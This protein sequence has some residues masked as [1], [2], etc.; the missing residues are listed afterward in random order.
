MIKKKLFLSDE[1]IKELTEDAFGYNAYVQTLYRCIK[2][3][4]CGIN[5]GLFGKWGV[6]DLT[7]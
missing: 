6:G 4:D 1:P 3:C 2:E 5:I 7:P